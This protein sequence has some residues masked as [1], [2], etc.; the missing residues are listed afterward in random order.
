M[1]TPKDEN[2]DIIAKICS[3]I[4][5]VPI[6]AISFVDTETFYIKSIFG[7]KFDATRVDRKIT[8][9]ENTIKQND[10]LVIN[11]TLK[12]NR[13]KDN[14]FVLNHPFIRFKLVCP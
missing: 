11:D 3:I 9:C 13:V 8:F 5:R 10:V 1:D 4:F 6:N 2:F 12:D 14:P 7:L